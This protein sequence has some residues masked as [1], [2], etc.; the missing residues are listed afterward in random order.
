[1]PRRTFDCFTFFNERKLLQLRV[2]LLRDAVDYFVV[3]EANRTF[4]GKDKAWHFKPEDYDV[5]SAKFIYVQVEDMPGSAADAWANERHQRN[6]ILR[7]LGSAADNDLIHV[8]DVDEIPDPRVFDEYKSWW[9]MAALE[10]RLFY[11]HWN[12]LVLYEDGR[13]VCWTG[14]KLTTFRHLRS[15][16]KNPENLRKKA[17][18]SR[19]LLNRIRFRASAASL[20]DAGWHWSYI[21]TPEEMSLKIKSFSHTEFSKAEFSDVRQIQSRIDD[22]AD[23]FGRPFVLR[24]MPVETLFPD[25]VQKLLICKFGDYIC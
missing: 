11:Y 18:G 25:V 16:W 19:S 15:F 3:V 22:A 8:S 23:R 17:P 9:I 12:K 13:P 7:G 4:T 2:A 10:Q 6:A 20:K 21:M 5:P 24:T 1:M 14:A